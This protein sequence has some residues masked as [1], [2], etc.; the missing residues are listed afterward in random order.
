MWTALDRRSLIAVL[1]VI[2]VAVPADPGRVATR[3]RKR[4]AAA[5]GAINAVDLR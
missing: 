1:V 5:L 3:G 4:T 2:E